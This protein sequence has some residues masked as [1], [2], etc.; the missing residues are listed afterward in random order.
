VNDESTQ[1]VEEQFASLV[2]A[3]DDA[4]AA[5]SALVEIHTDVPPELRQRLERGVACMK[6]LRQALPQEPVTPA[7]P[8]PGQATLLPAC[9]GRFAVVRELGRGAFGV[10]YLA[11]DAHLGRDVALKVPKA[12]A[13]AD[14]GLRERFV[15][16]ARAAAALD[17][18]NVVPLY[19][20]AEAGDS[21]YIASAYCPGTTLAAW[22]KGRDTPVPVRDA[23][24]LLATLA[25][26]VEHAHQRGVLH[27][28]L[29]PSNVLLEP[30]ATGADGLG[31]V[32]RVTD[33]GLAKLLS[34]REE[35]ARTQSGAIVGTPAY[36][37]PEQAGGHSREVGPAADV[38]AL[39]AILYELLTGR[40]PFQG[41]TVLDVLLQV[42]AQEPVPPG[43]LRA[44]LPRDLE[45]IC[46]KCLEK[47][48]ARRYASAQALAD[49]LR[50]F[51]ADEP[52]RARPVGR[53]ERLWRWCRR[54]PARA[55]SVVLAAV[56]VVGLPA[57][58][59]VSEALNAARL[60]NEQENTNKEHRN[61]LNA[62]A[63]L[64]EKNAEN[65]QESARLALTQGLNLCEQG[66]A[67]RG[68]LFLARSLE[69]AAR[70]E[71]PE[72]EHAVR[73]ALAGWSREVNPMKTV[74]PLQDPADTAAFSPDGRTI[75]T[76]EG[77]TA[78]LW[79]AA[80]GKP[81][82]EPLRH[83]GPVRAQAF[84]PDSKM[85]LTGSGYSSEDKAHPRGE[86][87]LWDAATGKPL[88]APLPHKEEVR[89]V[90][91]TPDGRT[92]FTSFTT[93][94]RNINTSHRQQW[95]TDG[96]QP[97]GPP[98][99]GSLLPTVISSRDGRRVAWGGLK[100]GTIQVW[101][102]VAGKELA[103]LDNDGKGHWLV[104]I[105]PDGQ[106]VLAGTGYDQFRLWKTA[107]GE[108]IGAEM[109]HTRLQS[110][111]FSPDGKLILTGGDPDFGSGK[112]I[113]EARLWDVATG[114][115]I[116]QPLKHPETVHFVAFSPGGE[117]AMTC[118]N[119]RNGR[120][121]AVTKEGLVEQPGRLGEGPVVALSPDGKLVLTDGAA[122]PQLWDFATRRLIGQP[123][124]HPHAALKPGVRYT[125]AFSPDGQT[126]L[127]NCRDRTV[128]LWGLA[129][130]QGIG[131]PLQHHDSVI[132]VAFD[133]AGKRLLTAGGNQP[134]MQRIGPGS[135]S[136]SGL[137]MPRGG[138]GID[139]AVLHAPQVPAGVRLWETATGRPCG[140]P[141]E[142]GDR[143]RG[144]FQGIEFAA[145]SPDGKTVLAGGGNS[146]R[147][148]DA[149]TGNPIGEPL[150]HTGSLRAGAFSPDGKTVLTG[151]ITDQGGECRLWDAATGK[152]LGPPLRKEGPVF[153]VAFSPDGK[154][155]AAA[156]GSAVCLWETATGQPFGAPL[157][158]EGWALAVA[159]GR[160][161]KTVLT[162]SQDGSARLWDLTT[163][164][165]LGPALRHQN[166]VGAL[167]FSS[168]GKSVLTGSEDY[169]ARLWDVA[170]G[171]PFGPPLRHPWRVGAV[172]FSPDGKVLLTRSEG[173]GRL[174]AAATGQP[175]GPPL[176]PPNGDVLTAA[177]SP[178]GET[179]ATGGTDK[180]A[181]L[182]LVP[183][184]VSGTPERITLWSQLLTGLELDPYGEVQALDADTWQERRQRLEE[185]GGPPLP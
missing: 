173:N 155:F 108:R 64:K 34:E 16:E 3:C 43:Q 89:G 52:V 121:S 118:S 160:D 72:L 119:T 18:P 183:T 101:D 158:R 85:V 166:R 161:G 169:T 40:P 9:V 79:D 148:W 117:T 128:R 47:Q 44:R 6:L 156:G 87:R 76:V 146:A 91:F 13:L 165:L 66:E 102:T 151:S 90:L 182:W 115:L 10:V 50:R 17:H 181:R 60:F 149:D 45:T 86:A 114:R 139:P 81:L 4:L 37:A 141:L 153:Q 77:S 100:P 95:Q 42:R 130:G 11:R 164:E 58:F 180:T 126:I 33:F 163:G 171:R 27:R 7:I 20:A 132:A 57:T 39:G 170:T 80:T 93:S 23:A 129:G 124:L 135:G 38:Y 67:G 30:C 172:A 25:G 88:G 110:A 105:S 122:G 82:G 56:L 168:N 61:T 74:L 104:A 51:L 162:G 127:M 65:E 134:L 175:L 179:V 178:D 123:L 83:E 48:P 157:Q 19:E 35:A 136:G 125:L 143:R 109:S 92:F 112:P 71:D 176:R 99:E 63:N 59:A 31:F 144:V 15:R 78:R 5:G 75:I 53:G 24:A 1:T 138:L 28:D 29:K 174:W 185:L 8:S 147:L 152:P 41:E 36:M 177:F 145:F 159:F 70:G 107:T 46:L 55:A 111:A 96:L 69:H 106:F 2:A 12:A 116:G 154:L 68:F 131:S 14:P 21:C 142:N 113:A 54:H 26:A 167:A 120:L 73:L 84:S 140:G 62:L 22:L 133:P 49:D 98:L 94:F 32:P 184:P 97:L 137:G 150:E 103:V